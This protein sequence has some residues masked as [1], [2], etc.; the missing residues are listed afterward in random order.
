MSNPENKADIT[1][2][3]FSRPLLV[4]F[5]QHGRKTLPWQQNRNPYR[6]W[7][8]EVMLQQTQVDT[9]IPYYLRF[10]DSFPDI[11]SLAQAHHDE[12]MNHWAGLGYYARA[13]NLHKAAKVICENH[14]GLFPENFEDVLAL[15]GIG[16]STAGAIL[17]FSNGQR[18]PILDGNVK[19]V[20][21]RFF[22]IPGP[23]SK[24]SIENQLWELADRLT[25]E[26]RI[27]DY[28]QAIMDLGA[29]LC[30]RSKPLCPNCPVAA[31]C[32][33]LHQNAVHRFPEPK[34]RSARTQKTTRM[35]V[36]QNL[37]QQI[38]LIKRPPTGIWGGL[39]SLP[40]ID[41]PEADI[42]RWSLDN[43]GLEISVQ[44]EMKSLR[45]SFTHFDLT[46]EPI[47]CRP[48]A[49]SSMIMDA[50]YF[51]WY[52]PEIDI[53]AGVPAAVERIFKR[54]MQNSD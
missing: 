22:A 42:R 1:T 46:I 41:A 29:T 34:A 33:A 16:R 35:L 2:P 17:A 48:Q 28:T 30:T 52:N 19:R 51:L 37:T 13:R 12:V 44:T 14:D 4:W 32:Q 40:Q 39:W 10:L 20:L 3:A 15:P 24:K 7:L 18:H 53:G 11:I 5:D 8:S 25:P 50:D 31:N 21:T 54:R 9:V 38:L 47:V 36:I 45:H 26:N 27:A 43:L 49:N 6:I 23:P